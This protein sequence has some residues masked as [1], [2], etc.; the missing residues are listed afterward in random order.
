M[1][2]HDIPITHSSSFDALNNDYAPRYSSP[3]EANAATNNNYSSSFYVNNESPPMP[4]LMTPPPIVPLSSNPTSSLQQQQHA[5]LDGINRYT[6]NENSDGAYSSFVDWV[7]QNVPF[8]GGCSPVESALAGNDAEQPQHNGG[9]ELPPSQS[10]TPQHQEVEVKSIP[11][12]NVYPRKPSLSDDAL[13]VQPVPRFDNNSSWLSGHSYLIATAAANAPSSSTTVPLTKTPSSPNDVRLDKGDVVAVT[14][15]AAPT[16][17]QPSKRSTSQTVM[18]HLQRLGG[19]SRPNSRPTSPN[20]G[21]EA[22]TIL[23]SRK[24]ST[25]PNNIM[26]CNFQFLSH[27]NSSNLGSKEGSVDVNSTQSGSAN[28]QLKASCPETACGGGNDEYDDDTFTPCAPISSR[29]QSRLHDTGGTVASLDTDGTNATHNTHDM[30]TILTKNSSNADNNEG[31]NNA[32][33]SNVKDNA[34]PKISI[35]AN[36]IDDTSMNDSLMDTLNLPSL[37][38]NGQS[39]RASSPLFGGIQGNPTPLEKLLSRGGYTSNPQVD[40]CGNST[41]D[42][43][44]S[45]YDVSYTSSSKVGDV[46]TLSSASSTGWSGRKRSW[47]KFSPQMSATDTGTEVTREKIKE[48]VVDIAPF[49]MYHDEIVTA[50]IDGALKGTTDKDNA[51]KMDGKAGAEATDSVTADG[52]ETVNSK[53]APLKKPRSPYRMKR[54]PATPIWKRNR[55][56]QHN[57]DATNLQKRE[58]SEGSSVSKEDG[59]EKSISVKRAI[60]ILQHKTKSGSSVSSSPSQS[61]RQPVDFFHPQ[62]QL[63]KEKGSDKKKLLP[64]RLPSAVGKDATLE[65]LKEKLSMLGE[66][67]S[68][69]FGKAAEMLRSD[70]VAFAIRGSSGVIDEDSTPGDKK[71]HR[72]K[73]NSGAVLSRT[74]LTTIR[75]SMTDRVQGSLRTSKKLKAMVETRSLLTLRMGFVSMSY[76]VLLQW[77]CA[78][79]LVEVIVLRKMCREDFLERNDSDGTDLLPTPA[80]ARPSI[81]ASAAS[82]TTTVT[83]S[84]GSNSAPENCGLSLP[85]LLSEPCQPTPQSFLSVSVLNVKMLHGGCDDCL[86]SSNANT[87][88]SAATAL[89]RGSTDDAGITSSKSQGKSKGKQPSIRPYIRFVLGKN[90][91]CTKP[92]KFNNGNPTYYKSHHNSCLLPMPKE[93]FRWFA[94]QEDL[95]VEVRDAQSAASISSGGILRRGKSTIEYSE[96]NASPSDDPILAV[97]T[98]PLS[99]VNIEDEDDKILSWKPRM[100]SGITKDE[101]SSTNVTLPLRMRGCSSAPFGSISLQITIKV[102][103]STGDSTPAISKATAKG[104][105]SN[106]TG[107]SIE[108]GPITK[109]MIGWSFYDPSND[110]QDKAST[111]NSKTKIGKIR[112]RLKW[113]KQWNPKTKKWSTLKLNPSTLSNNS[114]KEKDGEANWNSFLKWGDESNSNRK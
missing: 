48:R 81:T 27:A 70:A 54:T 22:T 21:G 31:I 15:G 60:S 29:T 98:V 112:K 25:S 19:S 35:N 84:P 105:A 104:G 109:L 10:S 62:C 99:S 14:R 1:G 8:L 39:S 49:A 106:D 83:G 9:G 78:S 7:N 89:A 53:D 77:D 50:L 66:I 52:S 34:T 73:G 64:D 96:K 45:S 41:K 4:P 68:G 33:S 86:M 23:P 11:R 85:K 61:N 30:H 38:S 32:S 55:S 74:E 90:E 92:A 65:K 102:P 3:S 26:G 59:D 13:H 12:P 57:Q 20:L 71:G 51:A 67:E 56:K 110:D 72:R 43:S 46:S 24:R 97:V 88:W 47:K 63:H 93:E 94:G 113:S 75:D 42:G 69:K 108:L 107:E 17:Q 6:D 5:T 87:L 2:I 95:F 114:K 18:S 40:S 44:I 79:Q 28:H 111:K 101:L 82:T 76:G 37:A 58:R 100:T 16:Q 36:V 91:H 103:T 80:N